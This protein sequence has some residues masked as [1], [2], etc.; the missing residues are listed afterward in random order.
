[1]YVCM[2]VFIC[3]CICLYVRIYRYVD[4]YVYRERVCVCIFTHMHIAVVQLPFIFCVTTPAAMGRIW[5]LK[6]WQLLEG[7]FR[8][9]SKGGRESLS[10]HY[11]NIYIYICSR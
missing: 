4:V 7:E 8:L 11:H 3:T 5:L 2:Q 6:A 10:K 1:M 9:L